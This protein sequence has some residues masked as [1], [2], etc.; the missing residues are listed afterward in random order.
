MQCESDLTLE[1]VKSV[2]ELFASFQES[3]EGEVWK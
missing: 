3:R 2:D 1:Q